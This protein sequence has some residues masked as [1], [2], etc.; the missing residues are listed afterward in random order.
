MRRKHVGRLVHLQLTDGS[1]LTGVVS[2]ARWRGVELVD[3]AMVPLGQ[4]GRPAPIDGTVV[5]PRAS[6]LWAQ[7][8]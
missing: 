7:V 5:I 6:I 3:A 2:R 4:H 1:T 8:V